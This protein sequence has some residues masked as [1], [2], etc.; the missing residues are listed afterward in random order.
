MYTEGGYNYCL[1]IYRNTFTDDLDKIIHYLY[2][3]NTYVDCHVIYLLNKYT[4]TCNQVKL[5]F[6]LAID[7]VKE[8]RLIATP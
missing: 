6:I 5:Y 4:N 8:L 1:L 3:K 2:V 7:T